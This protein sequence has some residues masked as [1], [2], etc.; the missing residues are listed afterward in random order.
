MFSR[1]HSMILGAVLVLSVA[2]PGSA[3]AQT[4]PF[5]GLNEYIVKAMKDW[6]TPGLALAIVKNDSVIFMK[7]Y[8]VRKL[9]KMLP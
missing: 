5:K 2:I 9:A 8:G 7:G 4:E 3:P 6:E 1:R